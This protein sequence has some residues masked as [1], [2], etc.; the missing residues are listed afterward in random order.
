[1]KVYTNGLFYI[2]EYKMKELFNSNTLEGIIGY[3][4]IDVETINIETLDIGVLERNILKKLTKEIGKIILDNKE[5]YITEINNI[6]VTKEVLKEMIINKFV[7]MPM[8]CK[9]LAISN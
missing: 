2:A 5:L 4:K 9:S 8:K 1:M 7:N 3:D 6:P